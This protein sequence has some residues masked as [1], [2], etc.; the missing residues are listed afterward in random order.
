MNM[1]LT[2]IHFLSDELRNHTHKYLS[3]I[4]R[5]SEMLEQRKSLYDKKKSFFRE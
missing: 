2:K 5:F 4:Q 3:I 1:F